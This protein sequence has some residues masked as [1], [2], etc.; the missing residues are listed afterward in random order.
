MKSLKKLKVTSNHKILLVALGVIILILAFSYFHLGKKIEGMSNGSKLEVKPINGQSK[1]KMVKSSE[2]SIVGVDINGNINLIDPYNG[3]NLRSFGKHN[4]SSIAFTPEG[5]YLFM[6][7]KET[8]TVNIIDTQSG[9][10]H[11]T[12]IAR[13]GGRMEIDPFGSFLAIDNYN[14]ITV[15]DISDIEG[16]NYKPIEKWS[17][18]SFNRFINNYVMIMDG[19]LIIIHSNYVSILNIENG[20]LKCKLEVPG[21]IY[22]ISKNSVSDSNGEHT[23]AISAISH[24]P[25]S[26]KIYLIKIPINSNDCKIVD[27]INLYIGQII[28]NM[29]F[30]GN[31]YIITS[32]GFNGYPSVRIID[33]SNK[34]SIKLVAVLPFS[35]SIKYSKINSLAL[36]NEQ[37]LAAASLQNKGSDSGLFMITGSIF[38]EPD[39]PDPTDPDYIGATDPVDPD[40][41]GPSGPTDPDYIG[42]TDPE[43]D[44]PP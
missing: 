4:V 9:K 23:V 41:I 21:T 5:K 29:L 38:D 44:S 35:N 19:S 20:K 27:T 8:N 34:D 17:K 12:G 43:Y 24:N 26:C 40:Y 18:G 42:P 37:V 32:G 1:L 14:M 22:G 6:A 11:N 33:I 2:N 39:H 31:K 13:T 25:R 10:I 30:L 7:S 36:V 16:K 3:N 28:F 15:Y